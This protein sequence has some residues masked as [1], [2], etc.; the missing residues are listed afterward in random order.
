MIVDEA[1]EDEFGFGISA[2]GGGN[3]VFTRAPRGHTP[4]TR[5]ARSRPFRFAK[6][7]GPP[8]SPLLKEGLGW[9]FYGGGVGV[10]CGGWVVGDFGGVGGVGYVGLDGLE[11]VEEV[12]G[13]GHLQF[14]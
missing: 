8:P 13:G 1:G 10:V 3:C 5:F 4:R 9:G 14:G 2:D 7:A 11:G 12:L 6:G